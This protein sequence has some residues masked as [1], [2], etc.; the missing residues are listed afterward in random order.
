[1]RVAVVCGGRSSEHDVSLSSGAAVRSGVAEAGHEVLDVRIARSGAWQHDDAALTLEPGSGLLGADAVFPVLHGPFGEDGTVQGLLELLDVPY[2]GAGV[3]ASALCMDKVVF[4]EVLAAAGV[5]QVGY[6]AVREPRWQSEPSAVRAELAA[7]GLPL[8]VKPARLG[9]SVGIVKVTEAD[10]ID[11]ALETAF[12]HD[13]LVIVEAFSSGLEIE[14][15]VLGLA[16]PSASL[17]G[18]IVLKG[19]DWYDYEAKYSPGGM[20]LVVPARIPDAVA[21]EVRRLAVETFVRVGCAG[22]ARVDF[23]VEGDRVI[24][25]EL[26]TMPGFTQTSV[27]PKLWEASGVSFPELC[28]RLLGVARERFAAERGGHAF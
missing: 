27:Y 13:G 17:P 6:V 18:E 24:V 10:E 9:S 11:G 12:G 19:A 1:V 23:F 8:F 2:V 14:C 21:E 20:E 15:S 25:N 22:L 26:N 3:L 16:E 7:L 4:K 5:P 28:D